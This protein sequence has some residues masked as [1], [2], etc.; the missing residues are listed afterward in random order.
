M[1][2][3][4]RIVGLPQ[5]VNR[6]GVLVGLL[7]VNSGLTVFAPPVEAQQSQGHTIHGVILDPNAAAIMGAVV[8]VQEVAG[9]SVRSD[10][11]G[12]FSLALAR[13]KYTLKIEAGG[14]ETVK[15]SVTIASSDVGP[16]EIVLPIAASTETVTISGADG[17]DYRADVL[18]SATRTLT[19]LRDVPQSIAVVSKQQMLDQ[20]MKSIAEVVNYVPGITSHQGENNRDQLVIRGVSTSADFFLNGLRDDVQY[21]RDLYNL[22]RVEVLKGPNALMFGRGGGGGVVNRVAKEAGLSKIRE[23]TVAGGSFR[24]VRLTGDFDQPLNQK[25]ALRLNAM[26]ERAGSFRRYVNLERYGVNPSLSFT[27][28]SKT[29]LAISYEHFH[30]ERRADRGIPSFDGRPAD[31]A[32]DTYFGNPDDSHVRASVNRLSATV[33]R[34]AGRLMITNRTMFGDYDRGYQNYVPGAVNN[35]QT[36]VSISAYNN[37]TRRRNL[38]NQTDFNFAISTGK[39]KHNLVLATEVGRQLTDNLRNTGFFNNAL[40]S[41]QVPFANPLVTTPVTFRQTATDA[42]N[43]V[44]T[45]LAATFIQDQIELSRRVQLLAGLRFDY[46][47]LQF[48]N[49][50]TRENLRRIDHLVSPRTGI[51]LKPVMPLSLY[52]SYS[53]SYLPSSGDQ[54]S[55]LTSITQQLKPEQFTNYEAGA[56]WD[57]GRNL[58]LT[59]AVYR[60]NRTNT[61]A[62][63]PN[64]PTRILQTGS[65]QTNG[66]EAGVQGN[67]TRAWSVAGGY[68][69]QNAFISN[70]TTAARAGAQVALAPHDTFSIWNKYQLATKFAFGIGVINRSGMFAAID[71]AVRL[72]GYTRIDAAIYVPFS[73]TWKFQANVEN[74]LDK[75]YYLNAD[76]NN[77]ISPGSSRAIRLGLVTRF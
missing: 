7:L 61:R 42:N 24:N 57:V 34:Q 70:A 38:F 49:N 8:T 35:S 77:N 54:F 56:K 67:I 27:P 73:E 16:I 14:F 69:H 31:V 51:V 50:R 68:A 23:F 47:D 21:Y 75:K 22:D 28:D 52:A 33:Q 1:K 26:Y 53:V 60:Q 11:Y 25:L 58:A 59:T 37:A 20:S 66:F 2:T 18:S 5:F 12:R 9:H 74:L 40:T 30:D 36:L 76:G 29:R 48:H 17:L 55:S 10:E 45:R 4:V 63:D 41:I 13:G 64:D 6:I 72:P 3:I 39:A 65:Q 15:R 46:F 32:I 71:N 43:H 44:T 19:N 62:T